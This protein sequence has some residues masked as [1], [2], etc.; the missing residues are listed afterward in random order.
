MATSTYRAVWS[1]PGSCWMLLVLG[2]IAASG[3]L[4]AQTEDTITVLEDR[5]LL[6][7]VLPDD[8]MPGEPAADGPTVLAEP[9]EVVAREIVSPELINDATE[10]L[11]ASLPPRDGV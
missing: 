4:V 11:L 3:P 2:M 7:M 1:L 9:E 5:P 8:T 10:I 6:D